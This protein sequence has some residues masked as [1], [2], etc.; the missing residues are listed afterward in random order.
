MFKYLCACNTFVPIPVAFVANKMWYSSRWFTLSWPIIVQY[1]MNHQ[2]MIGNLWQSFLERRS[3]EDSEV[4]WSNDDYVIIKLNMT[5]P[6]NSR[7][8]NN[9]DIN[10]RFGTIWPPEGGWWWLKDKKGMDGHIWLLGIVRPQSW[11]ALHSS[12]DS[13]RSHT[14]PYVLPSTSESPL[15]DHLFW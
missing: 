8:V 9:D 15:F 4:R 2:G 12:Q 13:Y 5:V 7:K 6:K 3:I 14:F 11:F 1:Y 10:V